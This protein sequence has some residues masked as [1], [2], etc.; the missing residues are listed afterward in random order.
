[1]AD[2]NE[3]VLLQYPR[4][5]GTPAI[6][7]RAAGDEVHIDAGPMSNKE[8]ASTILLEPGIILL[9]FFAV[10]LLVMTTNR[11]PWGPIL[12][13]AFLATILYGIR[14]APMAMWR[15]EHQKCGVRNN[16]IYL[17]SATTRGK[18]VELDR[19]VRWKIEAQRYVLTPWLWRVVAKPPVMLLNVSSQNCP[20]KTDLLMGLDREASAELACTLSGALVMPASSAPGGF[21]V[22]LRDT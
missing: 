12:M 10:L 3:A 22:I 7:L 13:T 1:M 9:C 8:F 20:R 4:A 5:K 14:V 17:C 15:R 6:Q 16:V 2:D 18:W 19:T 21:E 11:V